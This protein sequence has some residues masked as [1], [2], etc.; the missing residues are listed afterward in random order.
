MWKRQVATARLPYLQEATQTRPIPRTALVTAVPQTNRK[1]SIPR[2]SSTQSDTPTI[3]A[4]KGRQ[5]P[6]S[7]LPS[8]P[9]NLP[10][11]IRRSSFGS[12]SRNREG[13]R[14]LLKENNEPSQKWKAVRL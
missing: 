2:S 13:F 3:K 11:L 8:T 7:N 10:V 6:I 5:S 1:S 12:T 9:S 4:T 14:E